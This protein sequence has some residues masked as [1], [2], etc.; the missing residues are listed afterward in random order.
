MISKYF[1]VSGRFNR[2]IEFIV[3]I[4]F[5]FS[6]SSCVT[7]R[8]AEY[9]QSNNLSINSFNEA[10][11]SDYHLKPYDELFIQISSIDEGAANIFSLAGIQ[12]S[13]SAAPIDPYAA[14]LLSYSV[15]KDGYLLL[16]VIGNILAKDKTLSQI[17]LILKDSLN[18]ILNQPIVSVKLVN[19]YISVLG[20]VR[21]PGHFTYAQEKLSVYDAIGLAG[22]ITDYGNRNEVILIRN[23]NKEN[24]RINLDL[25]KSEILASDNYYMRPNDIL[26]VKPRKNKFWVIRQ[27]PLNLLLSSITTALLIYSIIHE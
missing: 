10:E 5:V 18:H 11:F 19:R 15:D 1:K 14:S 16:P 4:A 23:A 25:S 20:E 26:Y 27:V 8:K 21:N 2:S 22:D 9:L 3:L 6:L 13:G 17:S 12:R 7:E 24:I